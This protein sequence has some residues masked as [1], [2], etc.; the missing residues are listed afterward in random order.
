MYVYTAPSHR[1]NGIM[2]RFIK[3]YQ[4]SAVCIIEALICR[5]MLCN[6]DPVK[7]IGITSFQRS[8]YSRLLRKLVRIQF[9]LRLCSC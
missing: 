8:F 1:R 9:C 5:R 2:T 4:S 7:A 6:K 3:L